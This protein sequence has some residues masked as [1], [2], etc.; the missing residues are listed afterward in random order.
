MR[1]EN[2]IVKYKAGCR[3]VVQVGS[4]VLSSPWQ[5]SLRL[6]LVGLFFSLK[7]FSYVQPTV[8][9]QVHALQIVFLF[10]VRPHIHLP[11]HRRKLNTYNSSVGLKRTFGS[12]LK[13]WDSVYI[14]CLKNCKIKLL[15]SLTAV[16]TKVLI[17][18]LKEIYLNF[19]NVDFWC[20]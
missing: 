19:L 4:P 1:I 20:A 14:L 2:N 15:L 8:H 9:M 10:N 18:I 13:M 6:S 17:K 11:W 16:K 5:C 12:I 3:G 7:K